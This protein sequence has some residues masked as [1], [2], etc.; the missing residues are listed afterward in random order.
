LNWIKS[1]ID[2]DGKMELVLQGNRAGTKQPMDAYRISAE[3][4]NSKGVNNSYRYY[5]DGKYYDG[6]ANIPDKYKIKIAPS[7]SNPNNIGLN[8]TF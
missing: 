2:G 6:W 3:E 7:Q 1:D 5:I 8:I 4:S